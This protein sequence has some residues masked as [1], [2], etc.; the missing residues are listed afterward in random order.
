[1]SYNEDTSRHKKKMVTVYI[2]QHVVKDIFDTIGNRPYENGGILGVQNQIV[3]RYAF[4]IY[5]NNSDI[6]YQPNTEYLNT[7]IRNW[8]DENIMLCGVVHSHSPDC[9]YLSK[10]D[11]NFAL[12][13][14][15]NSCGQ[16]SQLFFPIVIPKVDNLPVQ[17]LPYSVDAYGEV[18]LI[19]YK[20]L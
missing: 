5:S 16:V 17:F 9:E 15:N 3:C 8:F 20:I 7:I 18:K 12:S 6:S 13:I 10:Q 14:I 1:M 11:I 2:K 19:N 4:D